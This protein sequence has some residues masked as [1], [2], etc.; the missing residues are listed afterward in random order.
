[1][2]QLEE[3]ETLKKRAAKLSILSNTTL[4][5]LKFIAG[6]LSGSIGIISEA[7]HSS[8]DLLA[9][10]IAFVS[11]SESSKPADEDHQFGHGKYEDM[12][13][14]FEGALIIFAAFYIVYEALK[15]ILNPSTIAMDVNIGMWVMAISALANFLLSKYLLVVARKT[16][17]IAIF[18]DGEHLKTD[19]FSSLAVFFGLFFVQVTGNKIFDPVIAIVVAVIILFTGLKIFEQAKSNLLDCSLDE[20]DEDKIQKVVAEYFGEHVIQL[21]SLRTRKAGF[22]KNIEMTLLVNG[23]M[24]IKKGHELCDEIERRIEEAI[25]NT[26]ITIHLEPNE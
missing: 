12:S 24:H 13:G 14:L 5:T 8:S 10:F 7:I 11:V 15:K 2:N 1:M 25:G 20:D 26:D 6:F 17:S 9:S 16:D 19:V 18:A 4:I 3:H 23:R 22:K 21:K